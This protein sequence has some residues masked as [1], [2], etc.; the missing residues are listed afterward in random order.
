MPSAMANGG[1]GRGERGLRVM[2]LLTLGMLLV[3][4]VIGLAGNRPGPASAPTAEVSH[5]TTASATPRPTPTATT[6]P[7]PSQTP[8][9]TDA[10]TAAAPLGPQVIITVRDPIAEYVE[11]QNIGDMAISL[12]GWRL[13]S[14]RGNQ[15]CWLG[16][17]LYPGERLRIWADS[18][19][20]VGLHC[21]FRR[22]IWSNTQ[23][24]AA[25][26]YNA[27]GEVVSRLE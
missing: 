21:R 12:D 26:L 15:V 17:P 16:G 27:Q 2:A 8:T 1:Q 14:E 11:I 22:N 7:L 25:V 10:P 20:E 6:P 18:G 9:P 24:D 4:L 19:Y 3:P 5:T 13:V 23:P